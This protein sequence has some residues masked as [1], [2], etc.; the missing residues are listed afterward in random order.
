MSNSSGPTNSGLTNQRPEANRTRP[1]LV[2]CQKAAPCR[3]P[4]IG[5]TLLPMSSERIGIDELAAMTPDERQA[6]IKDSIVTDPANMTP[7]LTKMV[8]DGYAE[9]QQHLAQTAPKG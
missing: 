7:E 9:Y 2:A 3:K 5:T 6:A 8:G 1:A 4:R